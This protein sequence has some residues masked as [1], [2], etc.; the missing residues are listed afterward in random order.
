MD[1]VCATVNAVM[2]I[3][4]RTELYIEKSYGQASVALLLAGPVGNS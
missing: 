1:E 4:V 2:P 3:T